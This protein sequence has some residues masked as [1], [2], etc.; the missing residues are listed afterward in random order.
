MERGDKKRK[1]KHKMKR[2]KVYAR[3]SLKYEVEVM[4][5]NEEDAMD[6]ADKIDGGE[7]AEVT[8]GSWYWNPV[9]AEEVTP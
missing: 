8:E 3:S 5:E 1:G 9:R 4:A 7:W 2:Y 6:K